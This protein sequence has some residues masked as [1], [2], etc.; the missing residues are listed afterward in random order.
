MKMMREDGA[1][2]PEENKPKEIVFDGVEDVPLLLANAFLLQGSDSPN[3]CILNIGQYATPII[4]GTTE[5]R[6]EVLRDMPA[7]HAKTI[8]RIVLTSDKLAAL[9]DILNQFVGLLATAQRNAQEEEK[10]SNAS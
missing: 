8:A 6:A 5:D 1:P 4:S 10:D 7:F 9:A 2:V 3:L